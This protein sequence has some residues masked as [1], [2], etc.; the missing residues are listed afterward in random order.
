MGCTAKQETPAQNTSLPNDSLVSEQNLDLPA[1]VASVNGEE[2]TS[3]EIEN[4]NF[5]IQA[6][7]MSLTVDELVDQAVRQK[8]LIQM[9]DESSQDYTPEE[10]EA[11]FLG[12][13]V[14]LEELKTAV[15]SD[16]LDYNQFLLD[17]SIELK[18]M[19]F[20]M[21]IQEGVEVTEEEMLTLFEQQK[22]FLEEGVT[23]EE[24]K[25]DIYSFILEQKSNEV[26][27]SMIEEKMAESD[28]QLYY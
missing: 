13:G 9:A 8:L 17:Y 10:V 7:G 16:G 28:I 23:Y 20:V 22:P 15:E 11:F 1:I 6:Y 3:E 2:I 18:V 24:I 12:E 26:L 25:E 21:K 5:Q 19:D 27:M 4:L 14:S